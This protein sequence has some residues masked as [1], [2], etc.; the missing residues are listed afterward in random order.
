[1]GK[2]AGS[3][4]AFTAGFVYNFNYVFYA[5]KIGIYYCIQKSGE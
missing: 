1:M 4:V 3:F 2:N 5:N